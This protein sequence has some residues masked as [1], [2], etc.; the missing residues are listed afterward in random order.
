MTASL[1]DMFDFLNVDVS[2]KH[3]TFSLVQ[4]I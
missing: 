2:V 4:S 1:D 3:D